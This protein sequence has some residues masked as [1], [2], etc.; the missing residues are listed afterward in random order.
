[1]NGHIL[2]QAQHRPYLTRKTWRLLS[3]DPDRYTLHA[4]HKR[5]AVPQTIFVLTLVA[6]FALGW[7]LY[8]ASTKAQLA[9]QYVEYSH[10]VLGAISNSEDQLMR[11]DAA[12]RAYVVTGNTSFLA[13]RD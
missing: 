5:K 13:E 4:H 2:S 10:R 9:S 7:M 1:M 12:M 3:A 11:A 8:D 6:T